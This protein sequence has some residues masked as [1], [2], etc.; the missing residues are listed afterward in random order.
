MHKAN[1]LF[2]AAMVAGVG[3]SAASYAATEPRAGSYVISGTVAAVTANGGAACLAKGTTLQGYSYF[4]GAQGKGKNF[5]IVI[6]PASSEP[7]IIYS[8]PPMGTFTGSTWNGT[9]TY[10]LPPSA[11]TENADFA[12]WFNSYNASSFTVTL[13]TYTFSQ[14]VG[15]SGSTC[16]T[17]YS[18]KFTLG[19][20]ASLF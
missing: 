12:L 11:V 17:T 9:L 10:M 18:L 15:P 14:G 3:C 5:T 6:P 8:F 19:L 7:G 20:P 4:P 2:L 13:R 16:I 1:S